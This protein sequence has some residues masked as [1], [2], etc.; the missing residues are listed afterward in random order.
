MANNPYAKRPL[1][2]TISATALAWLD[3][4]TADAAAAGF[5]SSRAAIAAHHL[6][7]A[8]GLDADGEHSDEVAYV[9]PPE[10]Y[11]G[12]PTHSFAPIGD[13]APSPREHATSSKP[14]KAKPPKAKPAGREKAAD[15]IAG[16]RTLARE[17]DPQARRKVLAGYVR[18]LQERCG[19]GADGARALL[20]E[21]GN[22]R[23]LRLAGADFEA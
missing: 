2:L 20:Q 7:S 22:K 23:K 21:K 13:A 9:E 6:Y 1:T 3:K 15:V 19:L 11:V 14:P 10:L 18:E 16:F 17:K 8:L 5:P 4:R 12:P